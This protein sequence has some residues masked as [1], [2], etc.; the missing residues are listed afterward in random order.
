[1]LFETEGQWTPLLT[2]AC[3]ASS[4]G[5]LKEG[6][7]RILLVLMDFGLLLQEK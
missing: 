3:I 4:K 6:F 5:D 1:M 2:G 7:Y